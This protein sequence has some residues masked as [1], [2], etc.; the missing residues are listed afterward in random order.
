MR[1]KILELIYKKLEEPK[2]YSIFSNVN[3]LIPEWVNPFHQ[4]HIMDFTLKFSDGFPNISVKTYV[5]L[6]PWFMYKLGFGVNMKTYVTCHPL[7]FELTPLEQDALYA[8]VKQ[9]HE[10]HL[11][12]K[13]DS[14]FKEMVSKVTTRL[15]NND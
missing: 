4:K 14:E 15:E 8:A 7:V 13:Y 6:V 10:R 9:H 12:I 3:P 11:K 5:T 1:S 2:Q